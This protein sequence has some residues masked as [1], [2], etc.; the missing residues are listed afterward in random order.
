[1]RINID[2]LREALG[3]IERQNRARENAPGRKSDEGKQWVISL[4]IAAFILVT[5]LA[6]ALWVLV[7]F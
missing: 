5:S 2:E 7:R 4:S 6:F 3:E 1:M